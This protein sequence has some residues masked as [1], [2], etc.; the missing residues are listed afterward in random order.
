MLDGTEQV[1]MRDDVAG[2]L[3][4]DQHPRHVSQANAIPAPITPAARSTPCRQR[5]YPQP[6]CVALSSLR[7]AVWALPTITCVRLLPHRGDECVCAPTEHP[8]RY[9]Q[10]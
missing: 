3:V 8:I 4:G 1:A 9:R 7:V 2:K 10:P 5:G 6:T